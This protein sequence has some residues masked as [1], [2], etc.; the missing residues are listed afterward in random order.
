MFLLLA[1][2]AI[3][4]LTGV[5]L[6]IL[7]R[8]RLRERRHPEEQLPGAREAQRANWE[9]PRSHEPAV[10]PPEEELDL[11]EATGH[12]ESVD[13]IDLKPDKQPLSTEEPATVVVGV[14]L[15][16]ERSGT[17][18][19]SLQANI[20]IAHREAEVKQV[21][22]DLLEPLKE[23]LQGSDLKQKVSQEEEEIVFQPP[24]VEPKTKD[25][26]HVKAAV[27]STPVRPE[28]RGGRPREGL[29]EE[30]ESQTALE[31]RPLHPRPPNPDIVCWKQGFEWVLAIEV[32]DEILAKSG[33]T[34]LQNHSILAQA[35]GRDSC[36]NLEKI[37]SSVRVSWNEGD[38]VTSS[39][40]ELGSEKWLLFK[41]SGDNR[42]RRVKCAS[43]GSYLVVVPDN[44]KR[45]EELSGPAPAAPESAS[46][47]DC[48]G[49]YF[50]LEKGSDRRIA[51]RTPENSPVVVEFKAPRFELVGNRLADG[52]E[53]NGP[54][55]AERPRIRAINGE[56]WTEIE[57]IVV[58][59]EGPGQGRWR[60]TFTPNP[61]DLEQDMPPEVGDINGAWYFLR[62]YDSNDI[63]V[64][65]LQFRLARGLRAIKIHDHPPLPS[66]TGHT[67]VLVEFIHDPSCSVLPE[68]DHEGGIVIATESYRTILTIPP[69]QRRDQT[70]WLAGPRDGKKA[71]VTIQAERI[72]WAVGNDDEAPTAWDD[73]RATLSRDDFMATSNKAIWI[74]L[75][76]PRWVDAV[77]IGFW[78]EK[79]R[80]YPVKVTE[81]RVVVPLREFGEEIADRAHEHCLVL[82]IE[83]HG[84]MIDGVIGN[85]PPDVAAP[86]GR[87]ILSAEPQPIGPEKGLLLQW[88]AVS[89][90]RLASVLT[91][92]RRGAVGPLSRLIKEVRKECPNKPMKRHSD[93]AEFV[94]KALCLMALAL[95][96]GG[97]E[98]FRGLGQ[99]WRLKAR[100]AAN[101]FPEIVNALRSRYL[102]LSAGRVSRSRRVHKRRTVA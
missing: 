22:P 95:Q 74:R 38:D 50:D 76:R 93:Q 42:G 70:H 15:P 24:E 11:S 80:R 102:E 84:R 62:F 82:S 72:W 2:A 98:L 3:A 33:L 71:Q 29:K 69:H 79:L 53:D 68:T 1:L 73:K 26:R 32:P 65:S 59:E 30:A 47:A 7:R 55:F 8:R 34:L 23:P 89:L 46:I 75:P 90:P 86:P 64:E 10:A 56:A 9:E 67:P 20:E 43:A 44:W 37:D 6:A 78:R 25:K 81:T 17:T 45:H 92:L 18:E 54:L 94:K 48:C 36:W 96:I 85:F 28:N 58:G 14:P 87:K 100:R 27:P 4:I 66:E 13:E 19:E 77:H 63:L 35:E 49:H 21:G 16:G 12:K 40:V 83:H 39:A 88:D 52:S 60:T 57:T 31:S 5:Y 101:T 97:E 61:H 51:F 99:K 41:L 91:R